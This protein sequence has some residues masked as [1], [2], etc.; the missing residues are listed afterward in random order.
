M[1]VDPILWT[2][3]AL[4][5]LSLLLALAELVNSFRRR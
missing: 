1:S 4:A 2:L 5:L 3:L